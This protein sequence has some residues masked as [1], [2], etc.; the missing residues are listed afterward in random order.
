MIL[1]TI[2][3]KGLEYY[4]SADCNNAVTYFNKALELEPKKHSG[5]YNPCSCYMKQNKVEEARKALMKAK[6]I[7]PNFNL[8]YINLA[9]LE[10]LKGALYQKEYK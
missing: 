3:P 8:T 6:K 2:T 10:A 4:Y 1:I 7:D 9:K 5:L